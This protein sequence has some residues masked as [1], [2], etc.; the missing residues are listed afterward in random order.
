MCAGIFAAEEKSGHFS[1]QECKER[2]TAYIQKEQL[3]D[4]D[5]PGTLVLDQQLFDAIFAG[6]LPDGPSPTHLA[7]AEVSR[8]YTARL[9]P[10][11]EIR[12]GLLKNPRLEKARMVEGPGGVKE[13]R[14]SICVS[15]KTE[16]RRGHHVTVLK[17]L[18]LI[19]IDPNA[20]AD[21]M[22]MRFAASTS[23]HEVGSKDELGKHYEVCVVVW[24]CVGYAWKCIRVLSR[25]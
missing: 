23:V 21:D 20:F 2:L 4:P 6:C 15:I 16:N 25:F 22:R 7:R 13:A 12:G 14:P 19:G 18:E 8:L 17:G 1:A 5:D 11:F 9:E 24:L 3:V 10:W